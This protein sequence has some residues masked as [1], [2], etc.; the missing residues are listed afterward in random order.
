MR[1]LANP[2]QIS[3]DIAE[4]V[5]IELR[6]DWSKVDRD[7]FRRGLEVEVEREWRSRNA[8]VSTHDL[9]SLGKAAVARIQGSSDHSMLLADCEAVHDATQAPHLH[10]VVSEQYRL[11]A[12]Q[13]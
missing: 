4:R 8:R 13:E 3:N 11:A 1:D 2:L 7:E 5:A 6:L 12:P 9:V 10:S